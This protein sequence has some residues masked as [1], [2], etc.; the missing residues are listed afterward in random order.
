MVRV[1]RIDIVRVDECDDVMTS[2]IN[3]D[4]K[5]KVKCCSSEFTN[6]ERAMP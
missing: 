2:I 4:I 5:V 6:R 3:L 1:D